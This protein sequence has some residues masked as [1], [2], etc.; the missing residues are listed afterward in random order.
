MVPRAEFQLADLP[1]PLDALEG[2]G[3]SKSTFEFHWG[4]HHRA[5]VTN[6]N[7]QIKGTDLEGK[8]LEE[9]TKATWNNGNP[10]PEFN[11]A[12]QSWNHEFFW[13][14]MAPNGGGPPTGAIKDAIEKD[15][16]GVE[17]FK[18]QFSQ[19]GATQFGSGWAWLVLGSDG[20][21]KVTKTPNAENPIAN[22]SG[23][24]LLTMDVWEHAYYLDVQ[25]AR[26]KYIQNFLEEL[27]SWDVVNKRLAEA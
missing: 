15:F 10:K 11:N 3:M 25:N 9:V 22:G 19:A 24:P 23:T 27:I 4:K 21:L 12:A 26:P 17:E 2:K 16:G 5:Y 14:S 13:N 20:K 8:S 1:Y 6:L 18:K 7:G